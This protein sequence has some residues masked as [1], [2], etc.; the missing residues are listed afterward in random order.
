MKKT[1]VVILGMHRSG[2]STLA[3]VLHNLGISMGKKLL[4]P[5]FDN[6]KGFFENEKITFFNE[7]KLL[8]SLKTSWDDLRPIPLSEIL[9]VDEKLKEEAYSILE[10][11]YREDLIFG[12][13]DPRMCI[14]FPFWEELLLKF[15]AKMK[16]IVLYRNPLEVA[17]SLNHR[18]NFPLGKGFLLWAKYTFFAEYYSRK[19]D[20]VFVTYN[21]LIDNPLE[22]LERI[23]RRLKIPLNEIKLTEIRSFVEKPLKNF[24]FTLKHLPNN[25]P[26]FIR[27]SALWLEKLSLQEIE[28]DESI[29]ERFDY[30][31]CKYIKEYG[32]Y[33]EEFV[34]SKNLK[35]QLFIDDGKGFRE[36]QS[37][38]K[39]ILP[40]KLQE[41]IFEIPSL[42]TRSLRFDP[43][44]I[45]C[46]C[47]I[48]KFI[49]VDEAGNESELTSFNTN[50]VV[51]NCKI[52][53]PHSD[54]SVLYPNI[55]KRIRQVRVILEY[56]SILDSILEISNLLT[57]KESE[58]ARLNEELIRK[59][60]E[61]KKLV[62]KMQ[63][64]V[65]KFNEIL[66][67][68]EKEIEELSS[69]LEEKD[70]ALKKN[71]EEVEN[72]RSVLKSKESELA[73]LNEELIRKDAELQSIKSSFTWR[74]V[75]K[76]HSFIERIA[77]LGTKRRRWYD[78]GVLGLRVLASEGFRGLW[79]KYRIYKNFKKMEKIEKYKI[80]AFEEWKGEKIVFPKVKNPEI[81][82]IIPVYNNIKYTMNCLKSILNNTGGSF[83]VIV[84]ND[85]STDDTLK[86]LREKVK[87]IKIINN[88]TNLGFIESCNRGAKASLGKYLCFL[89]NDT[90]VTKDWLPPLVDL[91]KKDFVGAVGAKLVY[92]DGRLQEA[93]G[94]IW[95]DGSGWNYGRYDDPETPEYNFV[96]EVD[97]CSGAV[98]MVK[99]D[100]F[101]RIG[102]FSLE[103]KPAYYEDTD[104][105]FNI[106]KF[107][108]KVLYQPK[109][110][111]IHYEGITSGTDTRKGIKRYQEVNKQKFFEKWKD[112]LEKEHFEPN[113]DLLFLARSRKKGKKILVIDHYV[114]TYDKDSGSYRMFNILK[115]L[116][117]LGHDVTFIGDN[118]M[119]FEPYTSILQQLGIEVI[120]APYH[121]SVGE[122]LAKHGKFFDL[123]ILSRSHI[124][125]KHVSNVKKYCNKAKIIFDTVDLQFLREKRRGEVEGNKEVLKEAEKL[126]NWELQLARLSD[127][128]LV[129]SEKEAEILLKE[130][131]SINVYVLSNIHEIKE[132][133]KGF[134]ERE[135]IM[136]LGG[137]N[138]L[139]N[140]D[141]VKWF[142][143]EIFPEIKKHL[144]DLK[145]Y[146]VGSEPPKE[147]LTLKSR[148][149]IVTGYVKDLEPYLENS[150]VFVAP[151]RY[152]AG[153]KGKINMAMAHGLP[154]VTT[155]I[156]AEGMHLIDGEN[157]LIADNPKDFAEKVV[158]L[159]TDEE[160]WKKLSKNSIE[161]TKKYFSYERAKERI[162]EILDYLFSESTDIKMKLDW[163][164]RAE[165]D[166]RFFIS[167]SKSEQ[168]FIESGKKDFEE[169]I[170]KFAEIICGNKD[171]KKMRV[172]EIGCGAGRIL[173]N[174]ADYFGEVYGVDVSERMIELAKSYCKN[175][176]NV[177]LYVNNGKDLSMFQNEFFD[178]IFSYLVFQHIP[179]KKV[180]I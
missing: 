99:K 131:P 152:G 147:I 61:G 174:M 141:G 91:I 112:V 17:Y 11:D 122:Y 123:V 59:D 87:N 169:H 106:R 92:P 168:E 23:C 31:R 146:V 80:K 45:P 145:F 1:C 151:L 21:K 78:L 25:T 180:I 2:T 32:E 176:D 117:E 9:S 38:T 49:L 86:I 136:F 153:V 114:P 14:V 68:K 109:S 82:I 103:F 98:L 101:E 167:Y 28:E 125:I 88:E 76:W 79:R 65:K 100:L 27:D 36:E 140:V 83:E 44:N 10:A 41:I 121:K 7:F 37:F 150:R 160:L 75:M 133:T 26:S 29:K 47:K 89:N 51:L 127:L 12:I 5:Q 172:L 135:G 178:F 120:Y 157:A 84:V 8:P 137:F 116:S 105:C 95:K 56:E 6:P 4:P 161:H 81:S 30:W 110:V 142:V 166:Y 173:K 108:Y 113:P 72:L 159:Y 170:L 163:N 149:I 48:K 138:H 77:P 15:G 22:E 148:D 97:Y 139:P 96:R 57:E 3:G 90:I 42:Y 40:K 71:S 155:S 13:K 63:E 156:G 175:K 171:P 107:G 124:A 64:E 158:K 134:S 118:L 43:L 94:I 177:F 126:R 58:L 115:I 111:V 73:R 85:A 179:D 104:L 19:Y 20:R 102:G 33:V 52:L 55:D 154:V 53:F 119:K 62:E 34:G 35:V 67:N 165:I 132:P 129:V 46:A 24:H 164:N 128:T 50:G 70:L 39:E 66:S 93:G 54:P 74:S 162:L 143:K 18:N 144:P 130:D 69:K 16:V 60:A